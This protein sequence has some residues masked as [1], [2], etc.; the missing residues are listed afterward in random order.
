MGRDGLGVEIRRASIRVTFTWRGKRR[1]E[2]LDLKPT[3]AN[4]KYAT[5]LIEEIRRKISIGSFD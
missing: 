2:T 3:P 4:V 1:R 5:R